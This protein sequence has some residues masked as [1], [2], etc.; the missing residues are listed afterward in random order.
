MPFWSSAFLC[1]LFLAPG[2]LRQE[3]SA[4]LVELIERKELLFPENHR[5]I[6]NFK[7]TGTKKNFHIAIAS[8]LSL[9]Q[10]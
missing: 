8:T 5:M 4:L 1:K 2:D 3:M 10:E 6:V 7:V 9:D